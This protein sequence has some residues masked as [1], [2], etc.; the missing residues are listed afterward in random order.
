MVATLDG[1]IA[2]LDL[3]LGDVLISS[4]LNDMTIIDAQSYKVRAC[5]MRDYLCLTIPCYKLASR[6]PSPLTWDEERTWDFHMIFNDTS[7]NLIRDQINLFTDLG[8][9]WSSG[10]PSDFN[11]FVPTIYGVSLS[12]QGGYDINL[13]AND[14]NVIDRPSDK[15]DNSMYF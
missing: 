14:H 7:S 4:S 6:L 8:K 3:N 1:Y 2:E 12:F 9:D 5:T 11:T 10:P 15:Q 13:F